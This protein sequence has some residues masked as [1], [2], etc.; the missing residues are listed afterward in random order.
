MYGQWRQ[1]WFN[2]PLTVH[3]LSYV[4]YNISSKVVGHSPVDYYRRPKFCVAQ[5]GSLTQHREFHQIGFHGWA[6][7]SKNTS[8]SA[9]PNLRC[10]GVKEQRS[11]HCEDVFSGMANHAWP[12]WLWWMHFDYVVPSLK[13][14][15]KNYGVGLFFRCR[16][17]PLS[18]GGRNSEC[19]NIQRNI[20]QLYTSNF[21]ELLRDGSSVVKYD[22]NQCTQLVP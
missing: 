2:P 8:L 6:A 21:E 19:L 20:E 15:E 3:S 18:S 16:T 11:R 7:A 12:I 5:M 13:V 22:S 4:N 14:G 10:R 1:Y 9:M 17:C